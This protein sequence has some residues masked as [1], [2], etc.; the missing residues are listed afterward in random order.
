MKKYLFD[1]N[2]VVNAAINSIRNP[3]C[4]DWTLVDKAWSVLAKDGAFS[5]VEINVNSLDDY[6]LKLNDEKTHIINLPEDLQ[7]VVRQCL[8]SFETNYPLPEYIKIF[9]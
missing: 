1:E 2:E 7:N 6:T 4:N 8:A 5:L 3:G 9:N